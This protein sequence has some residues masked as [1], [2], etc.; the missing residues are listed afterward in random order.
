[1]LEVPILGTVQSMPVIGVERLEQN[2]HSRMLGSKKSR[3]EFTKVF[4]QLDR[5]TKSHI[6]EKDFHQGFKALNYL[7]ARDDLTNLFRRYAKI[8]DDEDE[9]DADGSAEPTLD[10]V[11]FVRAFIPE[12]HIRET[13][14][15]PHLT[16]F[17]AHR[18]NVRSNVWF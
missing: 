18:S 6:T 4:Q 16:P 13:A 11:R 1:M 5:S 9:D 17:D 7:V 2:I 10:V 3:N 15:D 8:E 12:S 14:K